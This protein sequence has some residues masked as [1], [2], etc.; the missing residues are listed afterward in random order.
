[1]KRRIAAVCMPMLLAVSVIMAALTASVAGSVM[2]VQ[3]EENYDGRITAINYGAC[4]MT[5]DAV[6]VE[7][8]GH[9][10]L[11]DTGYTDSPSDHSRSTVI[12]YLKNHNVTHLDLYLSHYHNDHY[13]LLTTIMRDPYFTVG[14]VYL[15]T[16]KNL[17]K[18]SN[19]KYKNKQ[20]YGYF[21]KNINAYGRSWEKHSY[22]EIKDTIEELNIDV[23]Y[24]TKGSTFKVGSAVFKV[25]WHNQSRGVGGNWKT[26]CTKF[27]NNES[28]VTM[29]TIGGI[30]Y[31]TCGD[32]ESEVEKELVNHNV[33]IRADIA[34][35]NHHGGDSSNTYA[36]YKR[37]KPTFVFGTGY[38]E[39]IM[40]KRA[41]DIGFNWAAVKPNGI[42]N[43]TIKDGVITFDAGRNTVSEERTY[44]L[45]DGTKETR[46]F[47]FAKGY[48]KYYKSKMIPAGAEFTSDNRGWKTVKGKK[49]YY[50]DD[51][52]RVKGLQTIDGKL[53]YF[54][55]K[56]A[57]KTS[58]WFTVDGKTYY[59]FKD[60]EL[61]TGWQIV[62]GRR[63]YFHEDS[64]L[65]PEGVL[66][67]DG[68]EYH[69]LK[70]GVFDYA[71]FPGTDAIPDKFSGIAR[72]GED[73]WFYKNGV[74]QKGWITWNG[75]TYYFKKS[76]L[77]CRG[78]TNVGGKYY[79]FHDQ[80][81]IQK[82]SGWARF[83]NGDYCYAG[84]KGVLK[85]GW[86]TIKG[87]K[88]YFFN[89]TKIMAVGQTRLA[90][91]EYFFNEKGQQ[92]IN[93]WGTDAEG[94]RYRTDKKGICLTGWKTV[95]GKKYYFDPS[96]RAAARGYV[97]IGGKSYHFDEEDCHLIGEG[98]PETETTQEETTEAVQ[99][100]TEP[101]GQEETQ[102][103]QTQTDAEPA[104]EQTTESAQPAAETTTEKEEPVPETT[105]EK[106]EPVTEPTT[107][108]KP[109]N[110]QGTEGAGGR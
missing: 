27:I 2:E 92:V 5:G 7:S 15:P 100:Q 98:V 35:A 86:Q 18:W 13:Y 51:G 57:L 78:V 52:I 68:A 41:R 20:W 60:G 82:K 38:N 66:E 8:D 46:T 77:M 25:L 59:A 97:V 31:L 70:N 106:E 101:S 6:L 107:E 95:S 99:P 108:E 14:T 12:K 65:Q 32:L 17:L 29:V 44:R 79:F 22:S 84:S 94:N 105:T 102:P 88:Y 21:T 40:G 55:D 1:M 11:M 39:A 74:M 76:G 48:K 69:F 83:S 104:T 24:I 58:A 19:P 36:Y 103:A 42:L 4:G 37:I 81:G 26:A 16:N 43:Y 45:P 72:V 28:L 23:R 93:G 34:K 67:L 89:S 33:D 30:R 62:R 75:N 3:A 9:Y 53:Y 87:K 110:E 10:I 50:D 49:Y 90:R 54:D 73:G 96:T 63:Y 85:T 47:Y 64:S 91:K 71:V 80:T 61:K 56:R 109:A